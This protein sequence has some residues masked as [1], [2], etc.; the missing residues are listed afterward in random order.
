MPTININRDDRVQNVEMA[1]LTDEPMPLLPLSQTKHQP[2]N[3]GLDIRGYLMYGSD[4]QV[5]GRVEDILLEADRRA[6]DRE[7]PLFHMEY[8]VLRYSEPAGTDQYILVPMAVVKEINHDE[9]RVVVRGPASQACQ[10]PY[11]F[12]APDSLTREAEEEIFAFWEVEPRWAR[13]GRG[14]RRMVEDRR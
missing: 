7:W 13:S 6:E 5:M 8:A 4:G 14:P 1:D 12:Q 10:Q 9:R 3:E 11:G 2:E